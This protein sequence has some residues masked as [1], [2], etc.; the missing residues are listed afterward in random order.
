MRFA[1]TAEEINITTNP[2]KELLVIAQSLNC[3]QK[4]LTQKTRL[5]HKTYYSHSIV[6]GGLC[7]TSYHNEPAPS[8][9]NLPHNPSNKA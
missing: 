5:F 7:V 6:P 8:A 2:L 9:T 3:K 4:S 1:P